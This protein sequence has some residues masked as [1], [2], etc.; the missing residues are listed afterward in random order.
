VAI[1]LLLFAIRQNARRYFRADLDTGR[2]R[3]QLYGSN[4]RSWGA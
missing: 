4:A 1:N 2:D 3:R